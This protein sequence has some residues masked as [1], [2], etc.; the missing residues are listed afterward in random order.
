SPG[1]T[2]ASPSRRWLPRPR[3]CTNVSSLK[4][5][6]SRFKVE[7]QLSRIDNGQLSRVKSQGSTL[8]GHVQSLWLS[9]FLDRI[10][11]AGGGRSP[12]T[13][14]RLRLIPAAAT[15]EGPFCLAT[16]PPSL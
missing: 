4:A 15:V 13:S 14:P 8:S 9:L 5:Q 10:L 12:S 1:C 3:P 16:W 6:G 11:S 7:G 2:R